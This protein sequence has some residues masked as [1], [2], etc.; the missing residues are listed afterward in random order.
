MWEPVLRPG[1]RKNKEL[2]Y[3]GEPVFT[4]NALGSAPLPFDVVAGA[5]RRTKTVLLAMGE[6]ARDGEVL[7]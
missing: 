1:L 5:D 2:E 4:G 7:T 6:V 3:F